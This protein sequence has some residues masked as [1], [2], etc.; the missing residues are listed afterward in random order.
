MSTGPRSGDVMTQRRADLL[1]ATVSIAWG[2]SN[3]LM[4]LGLEGIEVFNLIALRFC[5]AFVVT[6]L[7]LFPKLRGVTLKTLGYSALT[8]LLVY[9]VFIMLLRALMTVTASEAGFLSS[10]SVILVPVF[11][12]IRTRTAPTRR[13]LLAMVVVLAGLALMNLKGGFR[14]SAGAIYALLAAVFS[15]LSIL[16]VDYASHHVESTV[17]LGV[18]RLG[19]AGLFGLITSLLIESPKLPQTRVQWA[20]ILG[21]A[22]ICSAYGFVMHP[23][24][25]RYTTPEHV[26]FLFTLEPVFSAI[27]GFIFFREILS[28]TSYLGAALILCS[29]FIANGGGKLQRKEVCPPPAEEAP[30]IPE[31]ECLPAAKQAPEAAGE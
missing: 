2:S 22:L 31:E 25:Q 29:V 5:I 18:F 6:G 8:G 26:V 9:G 21:L 16:V 20:A 23:V 17:Q 15:A 14:L 19:F 1:L 27:F 13:L 7:A 3:V 10:F 12:S 24:A 30:E 11:G 28:P 4:K